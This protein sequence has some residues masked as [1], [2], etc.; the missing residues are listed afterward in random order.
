MSSQEEFDALTAKVVMWRMT[1]LE[2]LQAVLNS[3]ESNEHRQDFT[4]RAA[5]NLTA[6]LYQHLTDPPPPGVDGSASMIV[7][8]AVG[9]A[10]HLPMESRDV[11]I[12]YPLPLDNVVP[13][14]MD[15][16]KTGLPAIETRSADESDGEEEGSGGKD[17]N[18]QGGKDRRGMSPTSFLP[19]SRQGGQEEA[20]PSSR[21]PLSRNTADV[22]PLSTAPPKDAGKV[23]ARGLHGRRRARAPGTSQGAGLDTRMMVTT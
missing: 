10:F 21:N 4:Q 3:P 12:V 6:S 11:A 7:E 19:T 14:L 2:G 9:I 5:T 16:E 17:D 8:L 23:R 18:G 20:A 22:T 1:T 13:H 15:V